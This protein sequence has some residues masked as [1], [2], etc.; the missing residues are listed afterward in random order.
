M[1]D[2]SLGKKAW[3]MFVVCVVTAIAANA[4]VFNTVY[5]FDGTNGEGDP[6]ASLVQGMD[7]SYYGTTS[8]GT[9]SVGAVFKITAA[10]E[11]TTLY[12]FCSQPNCPDGEYPYGGLVMGTDGNFYGTTLGGGSNPCCGTIFKITP[13]GVL[14]TLHNFAGPDGAN[15]IEPLIQGADGGFYGT[16]GGGGSVN[17]GILF[18]ITSTGTFTVLHDFGDGGGAY[19]HG[20]LIQARD[21]NFY[22]TTYE[23][24]I[25]RYRS[26]GTVT[27]LYHLSYL[28]AGLLEASDGN[29]YGTTYQGGVG[30]SGYG[31]GTVFKVTPG[32]RLSTIHFFQGADGAESQAPLIQ[33][34]DQNLYGMTASGGANDLGT[35]YRIMPGGRLTTLY[36]FCSQ[37]KCS[38]GEVPFRGAAPSHNWNVLWHDGGGRG[39][40]MCW[41]RLRHRLQPR[42]GPRPLCDFRS[43]CRQSRAD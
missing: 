27:T 13:Q 8:E 35:I 7:G 33:A 26:D 40:T 16:T 23:G 30:C 15:P 19:P 24:T 6:T 32:G 39:R 28:K 38:D 1:N 18:R 12:S 34:T 11:L 5:E 9:A 20:A 41:F 10:G 25:F 2:L 36:S 3:I 29:F 21:G 42:H 31:C 4:Q 22:G 43:R 37:P 17:V 14:T